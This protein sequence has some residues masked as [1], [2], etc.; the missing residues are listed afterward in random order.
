MNPRA[1]VLPALAA[2]LVAGVLGVQVAHGGGDFQPARAA[3][4]CLPRAVAAVTGGLDGLAENLVLLALDGA[5][6][7]LDVT[8]EALVLGLAEGSP[9]DS[10]V[11]AVRAGLLDATGRLD[12]EGRLPPVSELA[13]EALAEASLPGLVDRALRALPDSLIDN[14]LASDDL[15]RRTVD[16]LDVRAV[17]DGIEDPAQVQDLVRKAVT[18]ATVDTLVAGL[19]PFG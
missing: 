11:D 2:A 17:L 12:R 18:K 10:E 4:P 1:A 15:L 6:C 14:R 8:R 19:N 13:D 3:D 16:E 7:R 5:A 9:T